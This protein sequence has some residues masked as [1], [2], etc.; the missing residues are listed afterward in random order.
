LAGKDRMTKQGNYLLRAEH[1]LKY[2]KGKY[3]SQ[4]INFVAPLTP[5]IITNYQFKKNRSQEG[6]KI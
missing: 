4:I 5:K 1:P 6:I 2:N 3:I